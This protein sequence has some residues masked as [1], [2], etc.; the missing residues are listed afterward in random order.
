MKWLILSD[1]QGVLYEDWQSFMK[2]DNA[3]LDVIVTLGDIDTLFLKSL[4][5]KFKGKRFIGILGNHDF[6]GDLEYY[7]IENL[8]GKSI[9]VNGLKVAGIEGCVSYK[10]EK[11]AP[12][13]S[14]ADILHLCN[15][16][17]CSDIVFSHNSPY[18]IHDK[19]DKAH[20]GFIGLTEYVK[21]CKPLYVFHGHQHSNKM[22]VDGSTKIISVYGGWIWN[23]KE[24]SMTQVLK[25]ME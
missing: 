14:Q 9:P 23:Q 6:Y 3:D 16:L 24:D 4:S 19:E 11:D 13:Y 25:L 5:E 12:M 15:Q 20:I 18:G 17:P 2:M 21:A 7:G 8:H 1:L 10:K 22:T